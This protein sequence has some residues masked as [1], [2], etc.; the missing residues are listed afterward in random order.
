MNDKSRGICWILTE[1][2]AGM[3]N[4]AMGL[5][6]AL[7]LTP[8]FK[9]VILSP[10]WNYLP[11][12]LSPVNIRSLANPNLFQPP[13]PDVIISCGRKS[14]IPALALKRLNHKTICIHIQ[15]PRVPTHY[16]DA[17]IAPAHDQLDAS[18]VLTTQLAIHHITQ[19]KI[20][21][22][23]DKFRAQFNAYKRPLITVLVGGS[24]NKFQFTLSQAKTM[25]HE[26][27]ELAKKHN[28]TLAILPS[29]R[30][31]DECF[32]ALQNT[33]SK[34]HYVW[35]RESD[36]PYIGLLGLTDYFIA[37]AD[38]VSMISEA[39]STGKPIYLYPLKAKRPI[40]RF[41]RFYQILYRKNIA[42][43]F[44]GS[45]DHWH[46]NPVNETQNAAHFIEHHL[47]HIAR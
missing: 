15:N 12:L 1:D 21:A 6:F 32:N 27:A 29:R 30:T 31:E 23:A 39:A 7:K 33:L 43:P 17:I 36:N 45:L 10:P 24:S 3:N 2:A 13:Y 37:T 25:A 35:D 28:A 47:E 8:I 16:F 20:A 34:D 40:T 41:K 22:E 11:N 5:A 19:E 38:S 4:Q 9:K 14:V 18:N 26:L 42:R 46:Y 44:D